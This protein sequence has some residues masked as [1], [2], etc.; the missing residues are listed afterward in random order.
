MPRTADAALREAV[1]EGR[2]A[3]VVGPPRAGK[4][5][6]A[7][8]ALDA[9]AYV[10]APCD[11][12]ALKA[13]PDIDP[14]PG[15]LVHTVLWLD[16][17]ERFVPALDARLLDRLLGAE[18]PPAIVATMRRDAYDKLLAGPDE[19]GRVVAA[20]ATAVALPREL[21]ETGDGRRGGRVPGLDVSKGI[22]PAL[23]SSGHDVAA[24]AAAPA[25]VLRAAGRPRP[26]LGRAAGRRVRG[27]RG[28][29][30]GDRAR[31]AARRLL[32]AVALPAARG[33]PGR[34]RAPHVLPLR[35][36]LPRRRRR[37]T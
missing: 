2:F 6:S 29:R 31:L 18:L 21:D 25:G 7:L 8:E 5:R 35:R 3:L 28:R 10:I 12:D 1:Q 9:D 4:S 23:A 37:R 11:A 32:R 36:R 14:P 20:Y 19:A 26:P 34:R 30:G 22:G 17:L 15:A 27:H 13:L 24:A 33:D 16:G